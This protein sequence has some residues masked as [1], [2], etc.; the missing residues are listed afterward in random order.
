[1]DGFIPYFTWGWKLVTLGDGHGLRVIE[2]KVMRTSTREREG[3]MDGWT[4]LRNDRKERKDKRWENE[5]KKGREE[6][7][8]IKITRKVT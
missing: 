4:K 7:E 1:V 2:N 6:V 8:E 5:E 3:V